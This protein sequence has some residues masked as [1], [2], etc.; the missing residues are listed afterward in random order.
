MPAPD[1]TVVEQAQEVSTTTEAQKT[2]AETT[3]QSGTKQTQ[4]PDP[5]QGTKGGDDAEK[6]FK[7]IQADLAK[8]RK[9]R[10]QFE[11]QV[12]LARAELDA[13][14]RRVAALAGVNIASP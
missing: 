2:G 6:R 9:A 10:Q 3:D 4:R 13:E 11:Q 1:S 14:K 8:E 7:G 12:T 5:A